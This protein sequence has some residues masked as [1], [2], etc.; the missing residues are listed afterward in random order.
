MN[1][2]MEYA[3]KRWGTVRDIVAILPRQAKIS[4]RLIREWVRL[5]LLVAGEMAGRG[6]AAF[7]VAYEDVLRVDRA[8]RLLAKQH[9]GQPRKA[10]SMAA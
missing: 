4:A 1:G 2:L 9:G 6:R 8:R 10:C 3:G 7:V 5:G